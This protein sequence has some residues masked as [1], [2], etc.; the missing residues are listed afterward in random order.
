MDRL[1]QSARRFIEQDDKLQL[2]VGEEKDVVSK[3]DILCREVKEGIVEKKHKQCQLFFLPLSISNFLIIK[4]AG[5]Q[6]AVWG[7]DGGHALKDITSKLGVLS[8]EIAESFAA[9]G[10]EVSPFPI[11]PCRKL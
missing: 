11:K 8:D 9:F 7:N 5:K 2:S 1:A 10:G 3:V 6:L 4:L